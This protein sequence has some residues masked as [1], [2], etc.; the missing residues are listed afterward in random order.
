MYLNDFEMVM[1]SE[2]S[3]FSLGFE[4][5]KLT[6]KFQKELVGFWGRRG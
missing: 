6:E 3:K 5:H 1:S 2:L 4:T